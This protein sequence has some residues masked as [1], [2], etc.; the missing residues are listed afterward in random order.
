MP[1]VLS[2]A[3]S[4]RRSRGCMSILLIDFAK[5]SN[6]ERPTPNAECSTCRILNST[7]DVQRW[8]FGVFRPSL[9]R[10]IA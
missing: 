9:K 10:E 7:F 3:K 5:D 4:W 2:L 8:A 1:A 6:A